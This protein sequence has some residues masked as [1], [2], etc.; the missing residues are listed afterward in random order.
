MKLNIKIFDKIWEC[1]GSSF[2]FVNWKA[3]NII[4]AECNINPHSYHILTKLFCFNLSHPFKL[5]W[6]LARRKS[7]LCFQVYFDSAMHIF[8]TSVKHHVFFSHEKVGDMVKHE[9]RVKSYELRV[10]SYKLRVKSTS[11]NSKVRVQTHELRVRIH[12][13]RFRIHELRVPIHELRVQIHESWVWINKLRVQFLRS[14]VLNCSAI[15]FLVIISCFTFPS[16]HDYSWV[17][18]H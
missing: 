8:F 11:W 18:K 7:C 5:K 6:S 4:K 9:L 17:S 13:L 15:Q 14:S 3:I 1:S 2:V 16:P 12:E 10:T